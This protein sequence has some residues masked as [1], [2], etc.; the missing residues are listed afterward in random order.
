MDKYAAATAATAATAAAAAA[1]SD[2]AALL[3]SV[4]R[5]WQ[6]IAAAAFQPLAQSL[7]GFN[8]ALLMRK[9]T[10]QLPI[11]DPLGFPEY[12]D[13][14]R[15]VGA[16]VA[17]GATH[18]AAPLTDFNP[19]RSGALKLLRLRLVDTFG[20]V[21]DLSW[22]KIVTTEALA[23]PAADYSLSLPP[24]FSQAARLN[25]RWLSALAD[26]VEMNAHPATTPVCGWLLPNNL[27]GSVMFYDVNGQALGSIS[28]LAKPPFWEPVPGLTRHPEIVNPH[29]RKVR[30][31]LCKQ[32]SD[33]VAAF[34]TALD[35]SLEAI[36]PA[37]FAQHLDLALLMG[38]PI[39][40]VRASLEI[41]LQGLPA[42][43][44]GWTVFRQDLTR[45]TRETCGFE[46]VRVPVR[47]GEYHQLNDGVVGFWLEE[48]GHYREHVFYSP[49]GGPSYSPSSATV[50]GSIRTSAPRIA[51][52]PLV[53]VGFEQ[54]LADPPQLITML[55]DPRAQAHA[56]T[57]VLPVK[58]LGIPPDQYAPALSAIEI[59]FLSA[60][61]LTDLGKLR[62]PCP[63]S[64]AFNGPGC[65]RPGN[66]A[67]PTGP[68]SPHRGS[69]RRPR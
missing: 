66:R 26:E 2:E 37:S 43:H 41:E 28:S 38:R 62:L 7:G 21:K 44:Q 12:Q 34:L 54:S 67:E 23:A 6:Q 1:A 25:F 49:Q 48:G 59:T 18:A 27:D 64:P 68:R 33:F 47:L 42:V 57:G 65:N 9:Q 8:E 45:R 16:A 40:V 35:T 30:D 22:D 56:T 5:A 51:G 10:L 46:H 39:A 58:A 14:S 17:D 55:L 53:H 32:D 19:I 31:Y 50:K 4:R 20:Q 29:L 61:I 69:S 24:R 63:M 60:P 36:E 11:D 3:L 52:A 15:K 13:F